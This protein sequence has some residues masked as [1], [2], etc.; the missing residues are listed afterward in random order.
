MD[1]SF[2]QAKTYNKYGPLGSGTS[3]DVRVSQVNPG[4]KAPRKIVTRKI[5]GETNIVFKDEKG[6]CQTE[7]ETIRWQR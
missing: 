7:E 2:H 3:E 1:E 6:N 5:N 4:P